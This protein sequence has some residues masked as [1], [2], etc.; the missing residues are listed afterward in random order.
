MAGTVASDLCAANADAWKQAVRAV[1]EGRCGWKAPVEQSSATM[2][3]PT[4][5]LVMGWRV[6][7]LRD[8]AWRWQSASASGSPS[9]SRKA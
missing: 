5:R 2:G 3:V 6:K 8:A 4:L 9:S 1:V 7:V